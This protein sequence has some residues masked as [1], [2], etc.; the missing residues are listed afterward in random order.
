MDTFVY[1][2]TYF[3]TGS[4]EWN[5]YDIVKQDLISYNFIYSLNKNRCKRISLLVESVTNALFTS[6]HKKEEIQEAFY[7]TQTVYRG[8]SAL[9]RYFKIKTA[10]NY[11]KETDLCENV[12]SELSPSIIHEIYDDNNRTLY[13]FRISDLISIINCALMNS[14]DF[15][16]SPQRIRNPYT[17]IHLTEAQLYSLYFAIKK[18]NYV[19]PFLFHQYFMVN[20]HMLNFLKFNECYIR[21]ESIKSFIKNATINQKKKEIRKMFA[22][23]EHCLNGIIIHKE[24]PQK[25]LVAHF[26]KYIKDYLL[27]YYSLNPG[28]RN[29]CNQKI[30]DELIL[31]R[32]L[33]PTYGRKI[34]KLHNNKKVYSFVEN[35]VTKPS[36]LSLQNIRI[37]RR[38]RRRL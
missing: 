35:I 1:I 29:W 7:K 28:L 24:F 8:F 31:F 36:E 32:K 33:N 30:E 6:N 34:Q 11:D 12:L 17:N 18:S 21:E 9:A 10:R 19:M 14:P 27:Q 15:F 37:N 26:E 23:Y 20:F 38:R 5:N 2:I 25:T 13:S 4:R 16:A 3:L 22:D